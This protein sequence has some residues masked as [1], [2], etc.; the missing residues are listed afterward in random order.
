LPA[1]ADPR[2]SGPAAID[3]AASLLLTDL[4]ELNMYAAYLDAGMTGTAVFEFFVRK[5]PRG[6]N[7]LLAAGLEQVLQ[8]LERARFTAAELDWL[9]S[10]GRFGPQMLARL[11]RFRFEGE[12]YALPEGTPVFAGEPLLQRVMVAGRRLRPGP[13]LEKIRVHVRAEL[14]RL[15][16]AV[17]GLEPCPAYPVD[18]AP[19]LRALTAEADRLIGGDARPYQEGKR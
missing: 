5:L 17:R 14:E 16:E 4:Y 15:P 6:R 7:V 1:S 13:S 18:S 8:F 3:P 10:T 9:E 19:A 11:E 2:S 12:V